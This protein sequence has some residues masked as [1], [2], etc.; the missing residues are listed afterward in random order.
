[1]EPFIP[2]GVLNTQMRFGNGRN[3]SK[4]GSPEALQ[5]DQHVIDWILTEF[6]NDIFVPL[7]LLRARGVPSL[8][9]R[10]FHNTC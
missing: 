9:S 4:S 6:Q 8:R 2:L 10:R 1:M 7:T 5:R 3:K